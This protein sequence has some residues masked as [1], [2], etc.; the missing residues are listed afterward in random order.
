MGNGT[1]IGRVRGLGSAHHG[2]HHWLLQRFTAIGN[3]I[4]MLFLAVSFV[5]LPGYD[6][7][8]LAG[9]IKH[10]LTAT[11][12]ALMVVSTFWHA[13]LGLQILVEDYVHDSGSRFAVIAILNIAAIGGAAFALISIARLAFV[14]AA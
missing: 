3:L 12:L 5:L 6:H 10:P 7:G 9:W 11:A 1:E 8:T 2:V 4:L 14:G 13:R